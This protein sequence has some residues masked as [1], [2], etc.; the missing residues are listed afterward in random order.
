MWVLKNRDFVED[1]RGVI[2]GNRSCRVQE[3]SYSC[4]TLLEVSASSYLGLLFI[5]GSGK[6]GFSFKGLF[7]EEKRGFRVLLDVSSL[8]RRCGSSHGSLI[9]RLSEGKARLGQGVRPG[10]GMFALANPGTVKMDFM[11]CLGELGE[12][13]IVRGLCL[14]AVWGRSLG[15]VSDCCGLLRGPLCELFECVIA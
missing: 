6:E 11:V 8:R 10:M 14:W 12:P 5:F 4:I 2:S 9:L 15:P 1:L 7:G 13:V 3:A